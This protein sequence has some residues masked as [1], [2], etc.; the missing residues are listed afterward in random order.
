MQN[1]ILRGLRHK[2]ATGSKGMAQELPDAEDRLAELAEQCISR[3][4]SSFR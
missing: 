3:L 2:A 4:S 1:G